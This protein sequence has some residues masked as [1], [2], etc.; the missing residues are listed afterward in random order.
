VQGLCTKTDGFP[1]GS[2]LNADTLLLE[3][4]GQRLGHAVANAVVDW[5]S[6]LV[7]VGSHGRRGVGRLSVGSDSA[8]ILRTSSVPVL[9]VR[10]L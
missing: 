5:G 4:A 10:G 1:G 3:R 6:D 7:V 8:Q 9:L 2:F